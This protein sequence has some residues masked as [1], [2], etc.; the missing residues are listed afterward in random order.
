MSGSLAPATTHNF[1]EDDTPAMPTGTVAI[2]SAKTRITPRETLTFQLRNTNDNVILDIATPLMGLAVRLREMEHCDDIEGLHRRVENDIQ[3]FETELMN[4]KYDKA[5]VVAARYCLCSFI[6]EA[7]MSTHW[8]AESFW[9]EQTMLS[10]FHNESWGGEKFFGVLER[11]LDQSGRFQELLEFL[12]VCVGMGFEGKFHVMHNGRNM[13]DR[14]LDT[15]YQV[16]I[17]HR[18][19]APETLTT[20]EENVAHNRKMLRRVTPLWLISIIGCLTL[21]AL[22]LGFSLSLDQHIDDI[23]S[24]ITCTLF[25]DD[26]QC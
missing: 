26:P 24:Q 17:K 22:Y 7:V 13:L 11:V 4:R 10:K 16:L 12:Y 25:K 6:D 8:G 20:P 9:P 19:E 23:A 5:T 21:V 1:R 2:A 18:G 3:A 14:L 15:V